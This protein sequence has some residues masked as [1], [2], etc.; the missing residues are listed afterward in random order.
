TLTNFSEASVVTPWIT[1][2]NLS[3]A[4]Q[5]PIAITNLSFAY[6]LPAMSIVSFAGLGTNYPPALTAV[7]NQIVNPGVTVNATNKATDVDAPPQALTFNLVSAPAGASLNA[8]TGIFT[9]RPPVSA[10]GTTNLVIVQVANNGTP[11]LSATNSFNV[12]VNPLPPPSISSIVVAGQRITLTAE[13]TQG[14]D[15]TLQASTNLINWQSVLTTNS[16]A[17]PA[18]LLYTNSQPGLDCF[19]RLELGP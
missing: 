1:S 16:P 13:G 15:Y 4:P 7:P 19:F 12:I 8:S 11:A 10:A 3:L 5:S 18:T 17:L 6:T 2:G 9:W 14:P